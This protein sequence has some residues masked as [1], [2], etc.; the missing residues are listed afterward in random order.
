MK[1][2]KIAGFSL[3]EIAIVLMVIAL[4]IAG[5][6]VSRNIIQASKLRNITGEITRYVQAFNNFRDK[7]KALPGDFNNAQTFWG[8]DS[9]G[10]PTPAY[11]TTPKKETCNGDGNGRIAST[12]GTY[13]EMFRAWQQLYASGIIDGIPSTP[14]NGISGSGSPF[15]SVLGVNTPVSSIDTAGYSVMYVSA[16]AGGDAFSFSFIENHVIIVGSVNTNSITNGKFLIPD[17][18]LSIDTKIDDGLPG[19]GLL[20]TPKPALNP[21]CATTSSASTAKY[22]TSYTSVACSLTY[23]TNF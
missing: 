8:V 11:T 1:K 10:C 9:G 7:Y 21:N 19:S 22:N 16:A 18:A 15:N 2:L 17:D 12:A 13:Y 4:I 23:I 20:V 6:T 5:I 3:L 14:F